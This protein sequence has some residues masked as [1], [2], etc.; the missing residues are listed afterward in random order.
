MLERAFRSI[1]NITKNGKPTVDQEE[2]LANFRAFQRS[3]I[4]NEQDSFKKLYFRILDHYK[5]YVELPLH[6]RLVDHFTNEPGCE[7]V[8]VALDRILGEKPFIGGDY[9]DELRLIR[10]TQDLEALKEAL[11]ETNEIAFNGRKVGKSSMKGVTDALDFFSS[12]SREIRHLNQDFKTESQVIDTKEAQETREEYTKGKNNPLDS[13]GIYTGI[14]QIDDALGGLKHTEFMI[15]GAYTGQGKT[16]F[17]I[18][19]LYIAITTGWDCL[20]YTLEMTHKEMRTMIYVLHTSNASVWGKHPKYGKLV[21]TVDYND[22]MYSRL[23]DAHEEFYFAAIEHLTGYAPYGTLQ[24]VQPDSPVTTVDDIMVKCI[25][26]NSELKT[27]GRK[28]EFL[29]IDYIRLLGV[30]PKLRAADPRHNLNSVITGLKRLCTIF[31]NGQGLRILSPHQ[32][33]REGF[34]R[35]LT[36]GGLYQLPDLS[37]TSEIE[38]SADVLLTLFMD[39]AMRKSNIFKVCCLKARRNTPFDPFEA[40]ANFATK[41]MFTKKDLT[42]ADFQ[43]GAQLEL[44]NR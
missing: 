41:H 1:I 25:E 42:N 13:L 6:E 2:L 33:K 23:D 34:A 32:I 9:K 11:T 3:K 43:I 37:D 44:P 18:N 40:C 36:N 22:A 35:A 15:V 30:D 29:C 26:V 24:I 10:E 20:L 28:L 5:R 21:G 31:N 7:D 27:K 4:R 19:T 16:T 39:D 12:K 38:K 8:L 17:T 14:K